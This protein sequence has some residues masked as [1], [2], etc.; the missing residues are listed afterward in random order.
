MRLLR[1]QPSTRPDKKHMAT[2]C[3]CTGS[4]SR[5]KPGE[6]RVVHFGA[7]GYED[8][9]THGDKE[10]RRR[11]RARHAGEGEQEPHTPGALSWY[12]LWGESTSLQANIEAF[13]K[14]YGC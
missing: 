13:K 1:V 2:F 4:Q 14:K 8:Y 9:T 5:C 12:L 7:Q 3:L 11:Y 10:R 6:K